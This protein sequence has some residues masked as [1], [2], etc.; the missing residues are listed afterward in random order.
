MIT[1]AF[2]CLVM[3]YKIPM[4]LHLKSQRENLTGPVCGCD[5]RRYLSLSTDL[6]PTFWTLRDTS[7][8]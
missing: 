2:V 3:R 7:K 4:Q 6:I 1:S 5:V 8:S